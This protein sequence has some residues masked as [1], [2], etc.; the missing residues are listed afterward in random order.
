MSASPGV[1]S[2]LLRLCDTPPDHGV[3]VGL[4]DCWG[5]NLD[6]VCSRHGKCQTQRWKKKKKGGWLINAFFLSRDFKFSYFTLLKWQLQD[7]HW[8]CFPFCFIYWLIF[9]F[10]ISIIS[11]LFAFTGLSLFSIFSELMMYWYTTWLFH[12]NHLDW[13]I[14]ILICITFW[15]VFLCVVSCL[16]KCYTATFSLQVFF[17]HF[18]LNVMNYHMFTIHRFIFIC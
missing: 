11:C 2:V 8:I 17:I 15:Y 3:Y 18:M 10:F 7:T 6:R 14:F 12:I 5:G 1:R 9:L 4:A 16:S 13:C